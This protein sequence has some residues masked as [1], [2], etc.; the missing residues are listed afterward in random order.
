MGSLTLAFSRVKIFVILLCA[1]IMVG[2]SAHAKVIGE[3]GLSVRIG[4][5]NSQKAAQVFFETLPSDLQK[6]INNNQL[7]LNAYESSS[8]FTEHHLEISGLHVKQSEKICAFSKHKN[9]QCI[10][11]TKVKWE[12]S[13][14]YAATKK[15]ASAINIKQSQ[16]KILSRE[17]TKTA[18]N[19]PRML[20][21]LGLRLGGASKVEGMDLVLEAPHSM[22]DYVGQENVYAYGSDF[23]LAEQSY[24]SLE[25]IAAKA[26][27]NSA[28]NDFL[29]ALKSIGTGVN[30]GDG[31][32]TARD[33]LLALGREAFEAAGSAYLSGFLE[34]NTQKSDVLSSDAGSGDVF[35][36]H[37]KQNLE[38]SA[39]S[40]VENM[41][42]EI[43]SGSVGLQDNLIS[44]QADMLMLSGARGVIDAGLMAAKRSDLYALR[45]ME[46]EYNL[47]N[48]KESYLSIL[49]TQPVYQSGDLHHNVFLQGGG[50]INENSVDID[51]DVSRHT[52][53]IGGAYRYLTVDE[54]YLLGAN[55]FYDHQWPY[56]H[57]RVSFGVDAKA[58]DLNFAANYYYPL[59]NYRNSRTTSNGDEYEERALKGYDAELGYTL[60]FS[61]NVSVFG[62]GY[63]YFRDTD[64]NIRGL[65][66]S[67]EYKVRDNFTIK[68]SLVEENGGRDGIAVSLQYRLPL[69]DV[70]KPNLALA[71]IKPASGITFA[72]MRSK[73][74]EKVRREN[75]LRVEER[76]KIDTSVPNIT[77]QFNALSIGLPFDVGGA[78]TGA[79]VN[80]PFDTAI[81][82]PNG[83]FGIINFSNGAIAN[84]SASGGGD[85][86]IEFNNTTLSVTA[87]NGGFV[88]FISGV[89]GGITTV[90][91]PG[92]IVNLLG[93]DIDVTDDG[94]NTTIQVRAGQVDVVPTIGV[95]TEIG[96]QG[97][98][99][100]LVIA[101]G[102]TTLLVDPALETRQEAA[103][104]NLDLINP[105]PP[106]G[107]KAAP[108]IN[109]A[110]ELITGP[111]FVGNNADI[112]ITFTQAVTVSGAPFINGLVGINARI[113]AYNA[114][115][116]TSTKLVFRHVYIAGDIGAA[117][118]TVQD[119]DLNGGSII[120][121]TNSLN[122]VTAYTDTIVA[123][124]DQTA[125]SLSSSTPVDDE[126]LFGAGDNIVLNFDENVQAGVGNIT[127]TD[128]TNGS[129]TTIIPIG[130]VQ[131]SIV[132][133]I[134]TINP[135][136]VLD[137]ST[138]Y[139]LTIPSG[140][141]EDTSGNDFVG[142][143]TTNLNFTTSNDVIPP[144]LTS[145]V[146]IDDATN[147]ALDNNIVLTFDEVVNKSIGNIEIRRTA[148]DAVLETIDVTTALVTG[149]GTVN[150]TINPANDYPP[151]TDVYVL[152]DAGAFEDLVGNVFAGIA[153]KTTLNFSGFS[154]LNVPGILLWLDA[155]DLD[156]D[157]APEGAAES[158]LAAGNAAVWND[159]SGNNNNLSHG[160]ASRRPTLTVA[161]KNGRD[162]LN[163]DGGDALFATDASVPTL[164]LSNNEFTMYVVVNPTNTT[165]R[166]LINKENSYEVAMNTGRV[167]AAVSTVDP[168]GWGWG[169]TANNIITTAWHTVE[170]D[171]NNT[172]WD[173]YQD[174]VLTE[175][176]VPAN[177]EVGNILPSSS[178]FTVGA[179]GSATPGS[180]W[181]LGDMAEILMFDHALLPSER[182]NL[183]AY[184]V[185][186][187]GL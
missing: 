154:P 170:F 68:G 157:G 44:K 94:V 14:S 111:Q 100:N 144:A 24:D 182:T 135:T 158:G 39:I 37:V 124:T 23:S 119:L 134:V 29:T 87:T 110:P 117:S 151:A 133:S 132:G 159:K 33:N 3:G 125:P 77:A 152:V 46:L 32:K 183:E 72:S 128:T 93:T 150:I 70:N 22:D 11:L 169:G 19:L 89:S 123:I 103:Y 12:P 34:E 166:M 8:G 177:N 99:I 161:G 143:T 67:T 130:D 5:F 62:K 88:Q 165:S 42:D 17:F 58:K 185:G 186:K 45:N 16:N 105:D 120:G 65:E 82:V 43:L 98:V 107:D 141:I 164:D 63:Q 140:V 79:G 85:V 2:V 181:F 69:Y 75:R 51:D 153:I 53:N 162:I 28:R 9:M 174:G 146:P 20:R 30:E 118:V 167:Q 114:G 175:S 97:D 56:N 35:I 95:D 121:S 163:F 148:D 18:S 178:I 61:P 40:T 91:V 126:P 27:Y 112:R 160:A 80:L 41:V 142:I 36:H 145:S 25:A 57:S 184:L 187:W 21:P 76:L 26:A 173:F 7:W 101:T 108:F 59:T 74:F 86:I 180:A 129:S 48:F 96:N 10:G 136:G 78:L 6:I 122:A 31:A 1:T 66:L 127:I 116:S 156:G 149:G 115:A 13:P 52:L 137:L 155:H 83:D 109:V 50:I 138:D 73:A 4:I 71:D 81:T 47:N 60:P 102:V 54:K 15:P 179:R 49:L 106:S 139:D 55:M 176:I 104:T 131:I 113:F 172:S 64:E 84:L 147:V 92:G 90:N 38:E 171:H 168:G